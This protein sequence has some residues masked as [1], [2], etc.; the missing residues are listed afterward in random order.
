MVKQII[1]P[2]P[3]NAPTRALHDKE[4]LRLKQQSGAL[5]QR[6]AEIDNRKPRRRI[7]V[8]GCGRSGTWLLTHVMTT[9]FGVEVVLRELPVEY[10]RLLMSDSSV[11]VLV[12]SALL[13]E[14][15]WSEDE[16]KARAL[17]AGEPAAVAADHCSEKRIGTVRSSLA[18]GMVA[19]NGG[20]GCARTIID[21]TSL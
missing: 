6:L 4:L 8:M 15:R 14:C 21:I 13:R 3:D 19:G 5:Q 11:L 7:Y 16:P 1:L 20:S 10:F 12:I 17:S 18:C 2:N 9:F